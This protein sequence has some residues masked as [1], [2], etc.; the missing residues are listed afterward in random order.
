[1]AGQPHSG[2]E[3]NKENRLDIL[4]PI[5]RQSLNDKKPAEEQLV[6]ASRTGVRIARTYGVVDTQSH[7]KKHHRENYNLDMTKYMSHVLT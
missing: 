3:T 2:I 7:I 5:G 4:P 6:V 1:M